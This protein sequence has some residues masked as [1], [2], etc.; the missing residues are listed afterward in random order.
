MCKLYMHSAYLPRV[1]VIG[2][3]NI[4]AGGGLDK[5][6]TSS[7]FFLLFHVGC[8]LITSGK[9]MVQDVEFS[10][11]K[12]FRSRN[13]K[14]TL[15]QQQN[16]QISA[17][18]Q[19]LANFV[20]KGGDIQEAKHLPQLICPNYKTWHTKNK[21]SK[22]SNSAISERCFLS[23]SAPKDNGHTA[24]KGKWKMKFSIGN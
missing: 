6:F 21:S 13:K 5:M 4:F 8:I 1:R 10:K 18:L 9:N 17:I 22:R 14:R 24:W 23:S 2:S 16:L 3:V 20:K 19:I 12:S 7:R 15:K 11:S